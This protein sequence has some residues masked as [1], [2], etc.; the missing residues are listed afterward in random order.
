MTQSQTL[1][2]R[3]GALNDCIS[4]AYDKTLSRD[5]LIAEMERRRD[6]TRSQIGELERRARAAA[7]EM[8]FGV[9]YADG[10]ITK[11]GY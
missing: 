1:T 8:D 2:Q 11:I 10:R 3:L 5:E 4:L 9:K 7:A 6:E